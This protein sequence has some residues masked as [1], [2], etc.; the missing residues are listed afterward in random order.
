MGKTKEY[1]NGEVTVL[2][3]PELCIHSAKC[4]HNLPEVFKPKEKPW[5]QVANSN[6]EAIINTVKACPSGALSHYLN[7][8][9]PATVDR[10][11][12]KEMMRIEIMENGPLMVYGAIS[13]VHDDG[14]EEQKARATAFCR[15]GQS[16]NQPF[17]DGSHKM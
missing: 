15:C 11:T 10:E 9:G 2:W 13:I 6:T 4:V 5:V 3:K 17:C 16:G 14:R 12:K 1:S 8:I 7:A